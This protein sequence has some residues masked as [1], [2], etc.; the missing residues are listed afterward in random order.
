VARVLDWLALTRGLPQVIRTDNGRE[1]WGKMV[2]TWG[3]ER[4]VQLRMIQPGRPNQNAYIESFNGRLREERLRNN[5]ERACRRQNSITV[6]G[7][8]AANNTVEGS[9]RCQWIRP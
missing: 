6:P 2:V 8:T 4:G 1:F 3:H 7:M 9:T 5:T